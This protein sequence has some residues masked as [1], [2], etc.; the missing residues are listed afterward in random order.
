MKV[1][2]AATD[3]E[4]HFNYCVVFRLLVR[5]HTAQLTGVI[6]EHELIT[7]TASI[8]PQFPTPTIPPPRTR[9]AEQAAEWSIVRTTYH[10]VI[11]STQIWLNCWRT[12]KRTT[13]FNCQLYIFPTDMSTIHVGH[14][15][16]IGPALMAWALIRIVLHPP[17]NYCKAA[18]T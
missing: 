8:P 12:K 11:A 17:N 9:G 5:K 6:W 13:T 2:V 1:F 15:Y 7:G 4:I 3:C 18:R 10:R 14:Y 16:S